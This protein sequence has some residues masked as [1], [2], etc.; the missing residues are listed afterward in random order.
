[1]SNP[2]WM[3]LISNPKG[4]IIKNHILQILGQ[5]RFTKHQNFI[6]RLATVLQTTSDIQDL[7]ALM[8]S[9]Y[10]VGY[11]KALDECREKLSKL[12]YNVTVN[13]GI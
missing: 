6:E 11:L 3:E 8:T 5:N 10:E 2:N 12:G 13:N 7:G 1:M 9:V 4:M